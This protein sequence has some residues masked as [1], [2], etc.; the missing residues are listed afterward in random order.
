[1]SSECYI[2]Y[3]RVINFLCQL[4]RTMFVV[5]VK[6]VMQASSNQTIS[7]LAAREEFRTCLPRLRWDV[8]SHL[9]IFLIEMYKNSSKL[10]HLEEKKTFSWVLR[11]IWVCRF[12]HYGGN[13]IWIARMHVCISSHQNHK[14][15]WQYWVFGPEVVTGHKEF[16]GWFVK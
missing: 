2:T 16:I 5:K 10:M 1:M 11:D 6:D 8:M 13:A 12:D 3:I 4:Y 15:L 14:T 7:W 9:N